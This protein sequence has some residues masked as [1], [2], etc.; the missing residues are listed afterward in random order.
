VSKIKTGS[1]SRV[2]KF[3]KNYRQ[4]PKI[5]KKNFG[6]GRKVWWTYS[7]EKDYV[8][9]QE[10]INDATYDLRI[11]IV[12]DT[13][14]G[15]RRRMKEKNFRASGTGLLNRSLFPYEAIGIPRYL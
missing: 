12:G 1:G 5:V 6:L 13:I 4:A 8:Y 14:L 11:F 10:Y 9:F 15:Y 3:V 2:M 7:F